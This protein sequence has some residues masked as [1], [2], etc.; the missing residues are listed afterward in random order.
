[1]KYIY[2][3][4]NEAMWSIMKDNSINEETKKRDEVEMS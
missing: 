4:V 1:M 3:Y 2:N